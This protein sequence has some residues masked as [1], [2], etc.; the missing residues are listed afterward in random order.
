MHDGLR[1]YEK[2]YSSWTGF[3]RLSVDGD[4]YL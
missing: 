1:F 3:A 4:G 2:E